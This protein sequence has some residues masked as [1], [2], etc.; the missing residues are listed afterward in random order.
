VG[1]RRALGPPSRRPSS[2]GE[3]VGARR[4]QGT[5][6]T[7]L[8]QSARFREALAWTI[9]WE[10]RVHAGADALSVTCGQITAFGNCHD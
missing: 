10:R 2:R 8:A 9:D 3:S 6:G 5:A 7:G 4:W 1:R